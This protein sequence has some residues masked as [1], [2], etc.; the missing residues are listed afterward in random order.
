MRAGRN[1]TSDL[2]TH[3]IGHGPG[4]SCTTGLPKSK[5]SQFVQELMLQSTSWEVRS[6]IQQGATIDG[7][8]IPLPES[9]THLLDRDSILPAQPMS[10]HPKQTVLNSAEFSACLT[11]ELVVL[12]PSSDNTVECLDLVFAE[13]WC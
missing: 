1:I 5:L 4:V 13:S 6:W 9:L 7:E 10:H 3:F 11:G 8:G 12:A 2:L